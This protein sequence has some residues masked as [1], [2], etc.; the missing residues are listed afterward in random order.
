MPR[1]SAAVSPVIGVGRRAHTI[2]VDFFA[3]VH[4]SLESARVIEMLGCRTLEV[5]LSGCS[6]GEVEKA[7]RKYVQEVEGAPCS[8]C[9]GVK[10]TM[11]LPQQ[12]TFAGH[13]KSPVNVVQGAIRRKLVPPN[14]NVNLELT[15]HLSCHVLVSAS[16]TPIT[17]VHMSLM[18]SSPITCFTADDFVQDRQRR[19]S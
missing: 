19:Q 15:S 3:V 13:A 1:T 14:V 12:A 11:F 18:S 4:C 8:K 16:A 10:A 6:Q 17:C 2:E 9:T 7:K 5:D